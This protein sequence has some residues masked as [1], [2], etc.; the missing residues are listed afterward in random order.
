M[1]KQ[2]LSESFT[3]E[4]E[5]SNIFVLLDK[6]IC[7]ENNKFT[8]SI[9]RKPAFSGE[10]TNF[11]SFIHFSYESGQIKTFFTL[12]FHFMQIFQSEIVYLK[13]IFRYKIIQIISLIPTM[14][15][16]LD[17]LYVTKIVYDSVEKKQL[18][19]VLPFLGEL[20]YVRK[21]FQNLLKNIF[22]GVYS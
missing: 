6:N 11:D 3:F 15:Q 20:S 1:T 5:Q 7:C 4:T 9:Y 21:Q 14:K 13:D 16:Y 2:Q 17:K 8:T 12:L 22:T 18:L 10:F 19:I